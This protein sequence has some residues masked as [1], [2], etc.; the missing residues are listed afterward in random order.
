MERDIKTLYNIHYAIV[1]IVL[2]K[3][4][5]ILNSGILLLTFPNFDLFL[6]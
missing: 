4:R 6:I 2:Y 1:C 3:K 5:L